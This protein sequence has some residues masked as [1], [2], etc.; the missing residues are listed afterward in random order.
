MSTGN[1]NVSLCAKP[2]SFEIA[3][4]MVMHPAAFDRLTFYHMAMEAVVGFEG[5]EAELAVL[6]KELQRSLRAFKFR[7]SVKLLRGHILFLRQFNSYL[8]S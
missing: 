3:L 6:T 2:L 4:S 7:V 5:S 8:K 1:L